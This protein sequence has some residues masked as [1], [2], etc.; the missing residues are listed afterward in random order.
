MTAASYSGTQS[1]PARGHAFTGTDAITL[2][3]AGGLTCV[4]TVH[5]GA[6]IERIAVDSSDEPVAGSSW[7]QYREGERFTVQEGQRVL[8]RPRGIGG[9]GVT[10]A[11][12]GDRLEVLRNYTGAKGSKAG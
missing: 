4:V 12:G 6:P 7:R 8:L 9:A 10:F 2:E 5:A 1:S 11:W 3:P